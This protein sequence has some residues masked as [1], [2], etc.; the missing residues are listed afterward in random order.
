MGFNRFRI[1]VIVRMLLL[2]LTIFAASFLIFVAGFYYTA[3][4]LVILI[5]IQVFSLINFLERSNRNVSRFLHAIR[6]ADFSQS[7][8]TRNMGHS[9]DELSRAF[10]G[11]MSEFRKLRAE[12]ETQYRYLEN[13][14][15]HIGVGLLVFKENGEVVLINHA[16][17][18]MFSIHSLS[19][20]AELESVSPDLCQRLQ[21]IRHGESNLVRMQFPEE[22]LQVSLYAT[23]FTIGEVNYKLVSIQNI[24]SELETREIESWQKLIR[25][26]THEIMNSITPISTLAE[27]MTQMLFEKADDPGTMKTLG[28][29]DR[30]DLL[31][32]LRTINRRTAGLLNFVNAYRRFAF[33]PRPRAAR[34][35]IAQLFSGVQSLLRETLREKG[36][37]LQIEIEPQGM[38]LEADVEQ[39]EQVLLNLILNAIQALEGIASPHIR[40]AASIDEQGRERILVEDNGPGI[41]DTILDKIFIPF[42]T[43]K[44]DG[45]GIGLSIS[46]QI[47]QMH[48]GTI[49]IQS[50]QGRGTTIRL[51]F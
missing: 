31:S 6:Y 27:T 36:I 26:L 38:E 9:F 21:Q 8:S 3:T 37:E 2:I 13:V 41:P 40:L 49:T 48:K 5:G 25:V 17:K 7:F 19:T 32:A 16:A 28:A 34:F 44:P 4:L 11:V 30:E 50:E 24:F 51:R 46:R 42:Y 29:E 12:R 45:S 15:H 35:P 39:I 20:I 10:D 22:V 23:E 14:I 33:V 47:M 18:K 1:L 43:T